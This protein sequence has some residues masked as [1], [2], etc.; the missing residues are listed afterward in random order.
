MKISTKDLQ[1]MKT[2]IGLQSDLGQLL[3]YRITEHA[4]RH[5]KLSVVPERAR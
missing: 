2:T 4:E 1:V 3:G 5:V